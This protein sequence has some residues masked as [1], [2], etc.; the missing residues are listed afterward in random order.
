[1]LQS[2]KESFT[3]LIWACPFSQIQSTKGYKMTQNQFNT[4]CAAYYIDPAIAL[5]NDNVIAA[6]RAG[7]VA[8]LTAVLQNEF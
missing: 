8:A 6:I 4:L 5:E 1:V 2:A 3:L 7:D